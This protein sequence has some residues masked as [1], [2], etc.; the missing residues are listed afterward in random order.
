MRNCLHVKVTASPTEILNMGIDH[1][2]MVTLT[3]GRAFAVEKKRRSDGGRMAFLLVC[4]KSRREFWI[5]EHYTE[6]VP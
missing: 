2:G 3:S 6:P 4:E 5:Y 1:E